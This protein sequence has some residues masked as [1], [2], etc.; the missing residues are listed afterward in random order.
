MDAIRELYHGNVNPQD[1]SVI[2]GSRLQA[3]M[4]RLSVDEAQLVQL[5]AE[6]EKALFLDY[7]NCYSE[8]LTLNEE[9]KFLIGFRLGA[10][11]A[12]DTFTCDDALTEDLLKE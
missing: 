5:L 11:L 9:D 4:Q 12:L 1:R 10:R 2:P 3:Q 6:K 8:V 7:V